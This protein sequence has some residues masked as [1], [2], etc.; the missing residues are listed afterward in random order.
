MLNVLETYRVLRL[1]RGGW[2]RPWLGPALRGITGSRLKAKV[3]RFPAFE[4]ETH[5]L[6]CKGCPHMIGCPYGEVMEP[7][8]PPGTHVA[9]GWADTT[10]PI[11]I[12]AQFP[13][14][15]RVE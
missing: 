10:R 11:V 8:P 5:W 4:R 15:D 13:L 2:L 6:Y 14:P 9:G 1:A 12:A 3:C 7:D